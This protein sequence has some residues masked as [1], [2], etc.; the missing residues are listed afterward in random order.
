M[1]ATRQALV[2]AAAAEFAEK[3]LDAPSLDAICARA[4]FTRGA[5][6]VHFRHREELV[7]AAMEHALSLFLDAVIQGGTES[8]DLD[9]IVDRFVTM[10]ARGIEDLGGA[11]VDPLPG[12]AAGVPF[13]QLLAACQRNEEVR[14][15]FVAIMDE[16]RKRVAGETA[17]AQ[18]SGRVRRD[19]DALAQAQ[20]L[21]LLALGVSAA[22]DL[23]LPV[24]IGR[25]RDALLKWLAGPPASDAS[26]G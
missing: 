20:L 16:A 2:E 5:F 26:G 14:A 15:R 22:A 18:A 25:A 17:A 12:L 23:R 1:Q 19:G 24:D 4:G 21:V 13:H 11:A 10:A 3:G 8:G 9:A 7:A 6:Y